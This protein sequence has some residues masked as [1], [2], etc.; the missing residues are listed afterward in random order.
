MLIEIN[1]LISSNCKKKREFSWFCDFTGETSNISRNFSVIKVEMQIKAFGHFFDGQFVG[2]AIGVY[3]ILFMIY[4]LFFDIRIL[5]VNDAVSIVVI[6]IITLGIIAL[7]FLLIQ[8]FLKV[9]Y[10]RMFI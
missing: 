7:S 1:C 5:E 4:S 3:D 9:L 6:T 10:T 8:G 2:I